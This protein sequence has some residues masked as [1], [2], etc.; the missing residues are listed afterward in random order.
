M[1]KAGVPEG[2]VYPCGLLDRAYGSDGGFH[3][4][5][6]VPAVAFLCR[7]GETETGLRDFWM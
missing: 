5:Y 6:H 3:A 7:R 2:T 1:G 4:G